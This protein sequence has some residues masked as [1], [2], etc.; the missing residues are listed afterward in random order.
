MYGNEFS[1]IASL[2]IATLRS[3]GKAI[4]EV[5]SLGPEGV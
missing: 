4:V 3:L 5:L 2:F 1:H